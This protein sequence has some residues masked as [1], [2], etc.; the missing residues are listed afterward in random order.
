VGEQGESREDA[1]E[2][3]RGGGIKVGEEE[4]RTE[5]V[6]RVGTVHMAS[7]APECVR[8]DVHIEERGVRG[9]ADRELDAK[10]KKEGGGGGVLYISCVPMR[11]SNK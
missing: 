4:Q 8:V 5:H 6:I 2:K 10:E 1:K 7:W 11:G 3:E 9:S